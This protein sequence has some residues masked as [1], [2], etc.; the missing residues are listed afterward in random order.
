MTDRRRHPRRRGVPAT[1]ALVAVAAAAAF[2][3]PPLRTVSATPV[4]HYASGIFEAGGA[5]IVRYDRKTRRIFA[6]NAAAAAVDVLD[7]SDPGD[8]VKVASIDVAARLAEADGFTGAVAGANGI[9]VRKGILAVAVEADPKTDSGWAA[10]F[11][12]DD[13]SLIAWV[14]AGPLPDMITFSPN[15]KFV[16][17]ANEGEPNSYGEE[18]SVDPAGSVTVIRPRAGFRRLDAVEVGFGEFDGEED[19]LRAA[20]VRIFGPGASASMDFEP[21]YIAVTANSRTAYVTLQENNAVAVLDLRSLAFTD[22]LPL[23]W[24]DHSLPGSGLDPSDRDGEDSGPAA[25]IGNW[26]VR[27]L[28]MPDAIAVYRVKGRDYFVTANEGDSREDWYEEEARVNSLDLDPVAF[29]GAAALQQNAQL[30]RLTVTTT[31]GDDDGDEDFDALYAFGARSFSIWDDGGNLVFDSG[32]DFET[33]TAAAHPANFNAS[34]DS[35]SMDNRSDNKG[36]EPEGVVLGVVRGRTYA[37]IG[38]ER[39][40]GVMIYDVTVPAEATFVQYVNRRDFSVAP[41]EGDAGD[42]GP[43]GLEFVPGRGSGPAMLIV[44]N[45]VSGT[46]TIFAV[47]SILAA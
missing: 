2:A 4:G 45:E 16:L 42:L 39:I 36:P 14:E 19:A 38:L 41:G 5:E 18:D 44:G 22:I 11:R 15:G 21:E 25:A 1:A 17:V 12:T 10:F 32:D 27:G 9:A 40:G 33:V 28:Y 7:A 31:L 24:K 20:G 26:P 23:G 6:V 3:A 46:T 35:N 29:P 43:E 13:L 47:E 37:F 30:G 8:P 34:H